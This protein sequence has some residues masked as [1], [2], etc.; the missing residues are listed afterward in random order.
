MR[1]IDKRQM[2]QTKR[3]KVLKSERAAVD[4]RR[5]MR[6]TDIEFHTDS[7]GVAGAFQR[8]GGLHPAPKG[9]GLRLKRQDSY[10]APFAFIWYPDSVLLPYMRVAYAVFSLQK[11]A[12][13]AFLARRRMVF[14]LQK[15][16]RSALFGKFGIFGKAAHAARARRMKICG[17]TESVREVFE[18]GEGHAGGQR[19]ARGGGTKRKEGKGN[20][21][22]QSSE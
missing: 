10:N 16:A 3:K 20:G 22:F 12:S 8:G 2:A 21:V 19:P 14:S 15:A 4:K 18:G 6:Y 9:A 7:E 11:A 17:R 1:P 5:R 13:S